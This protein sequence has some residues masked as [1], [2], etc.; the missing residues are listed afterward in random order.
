MGIGVL[1]REVAAR[2][3]TNATARSVWAV[4]AAN[5]GLAI[6]LVVAFLIERGL[7]SQ[8]AVPI[9][10]LVAMLALAI[11]TA[12]LPTPWMVAIFLVVGAAGAAGYELFLIGLYPAVMT[13]GIFVLNRPTLSLV[14]IGV[15]TGMTISGLMLIGV[16]Y[17]VSTAVAV[18]VSIIAHVPY[19]PGWGPTFVL[20]VYTALYLTLAGIQLNQ[21]RRVPNFDEL[22][23]ETLRL[24]IEETL[25]ARVIAAVHDTV[26][27]DLAIVING[28]DE[29]DARTIARLRKDLDTL[30]SA[31]WLAESSDLA[32][33]DLQD[34]LVR[35]EIARMVSDLQ[36]R[37]LTVQVT[38]AGSGIYSMSPDAGSAIVN[39]VRACLENVL[40]HS[41][42]TVAD[43]DV[44]YGADEMT[45]IVT[46]QGMGLDPGAV[47]ADRLGLRESIV[48]RIRSA[49]GTVRIWSLPGMGTSIVLRLPI[50]AVVSD[51]EE[52]RHGQE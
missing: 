43:V 6:P 35:N 32:P 26:L 13:E 14:L 42:A 3:I 2:V 30:T 4:N 44:S 49:G 10:I 11:L 36:W 8:L 38:G 40:K 28:P 24:E 48:G 17:L 21:R 23:S 41:G 16:G 22:E 39:A 33:T 1:P 25:S 37:G 5:L 9:L 47:A 15:A 34:S 52:S 31:Q 12:L 19:A 45:V 27:N 46:D 51:F 20:V 29:L 50:I 7:G 18:A